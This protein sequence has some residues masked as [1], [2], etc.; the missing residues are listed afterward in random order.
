M[1]V[2]A[3]PPGTSVFQRPT[4]LAESN[5]F[6]TFLR[7]LT[8]QIQNQDPL[9]PMQANEFAS[10]L[11]SFTMVEQQTLTNQKLDALLNEGSASDMLSFAGLVGRTVVHDA[12]FQFTGSPVEFELAGDDLHESAKLVVLNSEGFIVSEQFVLPGTAKMEWTGLDSNGR[13]V[14]IA[15]Y[16]AE[17]RSLNTDQPLEI[18]VQTVSTIEEI[19]FEPSGVTFLLASGSVIDEGM[20]RILR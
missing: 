20:L 10:Q 9:S 8:T 18:D 17:L 15:T 3:T 1:D 16:A 11:A 7:M 19:R 13:F 14:E 2:N 12:Q 6:E 4:G 5:D